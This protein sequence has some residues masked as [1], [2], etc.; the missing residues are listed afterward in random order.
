MQY[1]KDIQILRGISVLLVVFYHLEI[2]MFK[3]GFLGV[4]VFFVISGFLMSALYNPDRKLEFFLKR[5]KRLLPSYFVIILATLII[6]ALLINPTE[7]ASVVRQSYFAAF[8]SSNIGY[9][10]ENSYFSKEAFNPLLHLWSLGV[11]IQFYLIIPILFWIFSKFKGSLLVFLFI[12]LFACFYVVGVSSKTS[13]F[14]MP[15]RLWEFLIGYGIQ[16]YTVKNTIVKNIGFSSLSIGAL[17]IV[18]AIP[19]MNIDGQAVGFVYGHPGIYALI[20][21][22]ATG[23][24]LVFGLPA[25]VENSKIATLFERLGHYSYSIYLVHFSVLTLFLY[26]PFS[27]TIIKPHSIEQTFQLTGIIVF[28]SIL[29]FHLIEVPLHHSKKIARWL[30]VFPVIVIICGSVG[31]T[32]KKSKFPEREML[33]FQAWDDKSEYRCGKLMRIANPTAISC[34]ITKGIENPSRRILLVGNSHA[35]SIKSTFASVA[36]S[37][38]TSV[39]FMVENEPL[40]AIGIIN[41]E[42]L[43][44]EAL[45]R[46]IDTIVLH[47]SPGAIE[48]PVIQKTAKLAKENG[49]H[50]ALIMPVPVW[51]KHIPKVLWMNIKYNEPLPTMSFDDYAV[52]N[53]HFSKELLSITEE[54]FEI[55]QV[56]DVFCKK[57]CRIISDEGKPLYFDSSHLTLT[58]SELLRSLFNKIIT[59]AHSHIGVE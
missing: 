11:E 5:A 10:L 14:M 44:K 25:F 7:F 51:N 37:L 33:I 27:G 29:M 8:F 2:G 3:G 6:S 19:M 42:G 4:D 55:Y 26:E 52:K 53:Q 20:V 22:L 39:R 32:F 34:E 41:P 48:I 57:S 58:G 43:I 17:M 13:F 56:A 9:W 45:N 35:D 46:K 24:I 16:R 38:N 18:I 54:N 28:L 59:D 12:S 30:L 47:Y 1:R 36:Q 50:L 23:V 15:L 49:I 31:V 40:M 21:S